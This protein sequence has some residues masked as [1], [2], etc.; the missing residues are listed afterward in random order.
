ME[1]VEN[2]LNKLLD[3]FIN[4][5]L[6]EDA[7]RAKQQ[8]LERTKLDLK[9]KVNETDS[10]LNNWRVKV[11]NVLDYS[12]ALA[13][14]F[15]NGDK[16]IKHEILLRVSSDLL[17]TTQN[18]LIE[19][20]KEYNAIKKYNDGEYKTDVVARTSKYTDIFAQRPDLLPPNSMM[21]PDEDSDLEP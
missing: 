21:L 19:L 9:Q 13:A 5:G 14:R 11:E 2:R 18:P 12:Q 1:K 17:Y 6:D 15:E 4:G 10:E 8:E 7:Y 16:N 20:K 3:L